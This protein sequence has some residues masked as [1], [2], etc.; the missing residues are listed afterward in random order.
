MAESGATAREGRPI[1]IVVADK[2]PL[3]LGALK[4]LFGAGDAFRLLAT[5][6]DGQRFL[7]GVRRMNFDVGIIGWDMPHLDGR[8]VLQAL[9]G[10]AGAPRIVVYT[11][12]RDADLP[13]QAMAL[14]A[15]GFCHKSEPPERLVETVVAVAAGRMVFPFVDVGTLSSDPLAQLTPRERQLLAALADGK[16]NARIARE[17]GIS[18][19][20]VK[21][22]LKN[23]YG[24]LGVDNRAGA[25]ARYL[26]AR[27]R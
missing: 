15:A 7:E 20:T 22:H 8:G 23:L 24:K 27:G 11:G 2:S 10:R 4:Q 17:V 9:H 21:F 18:L 19:H 3:V 6:S 13:R 25:V 26:T 14:G 12:N 1:E 5:A 16:G